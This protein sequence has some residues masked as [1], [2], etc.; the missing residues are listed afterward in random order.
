MALKLSVISVLRNPPSMGLDQL[1][2]NSMLIHDKA[3]TKSSMIR[4]IND[5]YLSYLTGSDAYYA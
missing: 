3:P 4:P 2:T 5:G 1:L